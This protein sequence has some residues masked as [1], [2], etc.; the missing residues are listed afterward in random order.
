[1]PWDS[2]FNSMPVY[3]LNLFIFIIYFVILSNL[4][5]FSAN[6]WSNNDQE[7]TDNDANNDFSSNHGRL[8]LLVKSYSCWKGFR[9]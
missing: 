9:F 3:L 7:N 5:C 8:V 6:A 4:Q 1:M 2:S